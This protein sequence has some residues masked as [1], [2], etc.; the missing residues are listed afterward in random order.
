MAGSEGSTLAEGIRSGLHP[1]GVPGA[2][3][4]P[5]GVDLGPAILR[6]VHYFDIFHHPLTRAELTRLVAPG[7][8]DRVEQS[9][10][11]LAQQAAVSLEG[12]WCA[13]PG[14]GYTIARRKARSIQAERI[15]PKARAAAA[16][17]GRLPFVEGLFVTGSLSK[18]S[19]SAD[20]DVDFLVLVS[21]GRVWTLKAA[22]QLLRRPLPRAAHELMC[23]NYLLSTDS[24]VL[25]EQNL[26]TAMELVTAVPMLGRR[27]CVSFLEANAW[28]ADWIPGWSWS[29]ERARRLPPDRRAPGT[30]PSAAGRA[31]E[32]TCLRTW[33]AYWDRKYSFLDRAVR[34]RRF[35]RREDVATNHLHDF[36]GF[37]LTE[38][39]RRLEAAGLPMAPGLDAAVEPAA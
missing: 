24:L 19:L 21:P 32:A 5:R 2:V 4:G 33:D 22:L 10:A 17:L 37:V 12:P 14:R 28:A 23:T 29:L 25:D 13:A 34:A 1:R 35:K 8:P 7:Q 36:Q 11:L 26:F 20:G 39:A 9:C 30:A 18:N 31:L 38:V 16:V 27:A 3:P 6:M 15:W